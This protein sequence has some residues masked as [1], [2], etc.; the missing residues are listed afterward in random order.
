MRIS[1]YICPDTSKWWILEPVWAVCFM[2]HTECFN[3][4]SIIKLVDLKFCW[5]NTCYAL[6]RIQTFHSSISVPP[7]R[8]IIG[9]RTTTIMWIILWAKSR[10]L[11]ASR[12]TSTP[13]TRKRR[14][15]TNSTLPVPC[16]I[17]FF[18]PL[19]CSH[20]PSY[21]QA[22]PTHVTVALCGQAIRVSL[23]RNRLSVLDED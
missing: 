12:A 13:F 6:Y 16:F 14:C 1:Q 10:E 2:L 8:A 5:S 22:W 15:C 23:S 4:L 18:G 21:W 17:P 3:I 11:V 7:V 20:C 9:T 19:V